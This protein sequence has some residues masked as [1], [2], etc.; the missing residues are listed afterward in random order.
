[1]APG[2]QAQAEQSPTASLRDRIRLAASFLTIIPVLDQRPRS[3]EEVAASFGWFPLIGFAIGAMLCAEDYVLSAIAGG[4]ARAIVVVITLVVLTGAVHLDGLGDA[5]DA[6]GAGRDRERALTIMRDSRIG[7]F[8]AVAIFFVLIIKVSAIANLTEAQRYNALYL[9]PG[10]AR[11]AMVAVAQRMSYLRAAGA[12]T[13]LLHEES[14]AAL[15]TASAIAIAGLLV[16]HN[17]IAVRG[18]LIAIMIVIALRTIYRRWLGGVTGDLIGAAD[19][20][21]ETAIIVA[22]A[23]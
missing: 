11:W 21:V 9:A 19:E 12:G 6:I 8:G 1:M 16:L 18:A 4:A 14:S 10:L 22:I 17:M 7:T 3:T 23:S 2:D 15:R 13:T 5:A 20:I